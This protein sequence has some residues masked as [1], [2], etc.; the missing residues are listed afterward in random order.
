MK[1]LTVWGPEQEVLFEDCK[2]PKPF[3]FATE[4]DGEH[5]GLKS[6][7]HG[8]LRYSFASLRHLLNVLPNGIFLDLGS[9]SGVS[10]I[11]GAHHGWHSYGIDFCK[12]AVDFSLKNIKS[13]EQA[14]YI[15]PGLV[16]IVHGSFFPNDFRV[17]R[18]DDKD[19]DLFHDALETHRQACTATKPYDHLGISLDQVDLFYHYQV[20]RKDNLLRLISEY[21]KPGAKFLFNATNY[22]AFELPG[23]IELIASK[24]ALFLYGKK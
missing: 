6:G 13:A 17:E 5:I 24:G 9:G 2:K 22:D 10:V 7:V 18:L 1:Q 23:N 3:E 12:N 21:A 16:R 20:E 8:S 11:Y 14:E 4:I 19:Q 15:N